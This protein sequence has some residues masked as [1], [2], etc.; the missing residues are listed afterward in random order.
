MK[1][2]TRGYPQGRRARRTA[3][4]KV[5]GEVGWLLISRSACA[6]A[7]A[8]GWSR[9]RAASRAS[10]LNAGVDAIRAEGFEVEL[11]RIYLP[12]TDIL[13]G[14]AERRAQDLLDFFRRSDIDA[15]FCARGGFGSVQLLPYLN[16]DRQLSENFSGVQR[17]HDFAQLASAVLR[18]G[19]LSRADGGDGFGAGLE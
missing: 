3:D 7:R 6:P 15:I 11:V 17:C 12:A 13:P 4:R 10:R 14:T 8:L 9:R 1:A 19:Y 18:H 16:V 2:R 5:C